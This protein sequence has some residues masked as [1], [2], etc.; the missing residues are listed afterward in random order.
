M[1]GLV[2]DEVRQVEYIPATQNAPTS[3]KIIRGIISHKEQLIQIISLPV[4]MATFLQ[5]E[6]AIE[7]NS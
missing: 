6:V 7:G 1:V 3:G 4:I 2:V 5:D